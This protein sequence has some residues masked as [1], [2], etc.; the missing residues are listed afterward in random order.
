MTS[1]IKH[2]TFTNVTLNTLNKFRKAR[3]RLGL[4][5]EEVGAL[6]GTTQNTI[7]ELEL[8]KNANPTWVVLSAVAQVLQ[9]APED[10]LPP[11]AVKRSERKSSA[12]SLE[13]TEV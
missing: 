11:R 3:K 13:A 6:A 4:T 7:S 5:Q 9:C 1:G 10:L 2:N 8:G 12:V